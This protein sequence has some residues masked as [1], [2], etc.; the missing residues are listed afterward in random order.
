MRRQTMENDSIISTTACNR[1]VTKQCPSP[2]QD[3]SDIVNVSIFFDGT[4][5]N[6]LADEQPRRWSNPARLWFA[7]QMRKEKNNFPI[8]I[9]G[10]GTKFNGTAANWIDGAEIA[11]QDKAFGN[12]GGGGGTHRTEFALTNVNDSLRQV[13][14][15]NAN[16]LGTST[17]AYVEQ[18]KDKSLQE[19]SDALLSHRLIKIINISIFGFSRGA[20]LARAFTNDFLKKCN[21][22]EHGI[23]KY[24]DFP[25]RIN[26]MGLFDTVASFGVP[27]ANMDGLGGEKNLKISSHV[28]RCVHFVA[29]HELRFSFPVD[30][31]RQKGKLQLNWSEIAFPGVH[32]DVGGGYEPET[33]GIRNNYSRIPMRAMMEEA[34]RH[35]VRMYSYEELKKTSK[36]LFTARY[37]IEKKTENSFLN[38]MACI[39]VKGSMEEVVDEHMKALYSAYG[40]MTR[41]SMVTPDL[42]ASKNSVGHHFI[43]HVGMAREAESLLHAGKAVGLMAEQAGKSVGMMLITP[44][45]GIPQSIQFSGTVYT[46]IVR[47]EAW[48]LKAWNKDAEPAVLSF[49]KDWVHDSKVGFIMSVEPFSYF[50]ARGMTECSHNVLAQGLQWLDTNA[51]ALKGG[52]IKIYHTTEGVVVETWHQGKLVATKTYRVGEKFVVDTVRAGEKYTVEVYQTSKNVVVSTVD[53]GQKMIVS[54]V[55][56]VQKKAASM[57]DTAQKNAAE[58][59][60]KVEQTA[61]QAADSAGKTV[62]EGMKTVEDAWGVTKKFLHL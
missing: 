62:D 44:V 52:I 61:K 46:Q 7:T 51:E 25:V 33:Q 57:M 34:V 13:L 31:I 59:A 58:V 40:T 43:G 42:I 15:N 30:L 48:R 24:N 38:Y 54:S 18:S 17:K 32:S 55:D 11:M 12:A 22:D 6:K 16:K 3:C 45:A 36:V 39:N 37:E 50:R 60:Q 20:A 28:E 56:I 21:T 4:G 26:F 27:S 1:D 23:L 29:A 53:A 19:L 47:P 35:G 5:N 8:Y 41:K 9:A 10:V 14:I 2:T 49:I